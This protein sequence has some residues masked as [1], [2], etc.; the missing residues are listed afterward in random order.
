[1]FDSIGMQLDVA[2]YRAANPERGAVLES[3]DEPLNNKAWLEAQFTSILDDLG[4]G[5][6]ATAALLRLDGI[7]TWQDPGP[8]SFYDDL[9]NAGKQ[10]H[11]VR[12]AKWA[13]DPGG[14]TTSMEE[15]NEGPNRRLSWEDQAQTL[16][17]TPLRMKYEG[18]DSS[19][20]YT[21]RV[22][23]A[24]RYQATMRLVA[25]GRTEI[26]G[27]VPQP[28][29]IAPMEFAVPKEATANGSL[30]LEWRLVEGRGC[31]VAEVWLLKR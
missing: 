24:G 19:A 3:L 26:H 22:T 10:P 4:R 6:S 16:F 15:F 11:L 20:Q 29:V 31:Q 27:P 7:L 21:V 28:N 17:G 8:G 14:V 30:E 23:Y 1:L 25:N 13:D 18:L 5:G 2:N 9:G 12:Q